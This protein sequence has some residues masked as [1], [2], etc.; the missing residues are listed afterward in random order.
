MLQNI[1]PRFSSLTNWS[2]FWHWISGLEG[3]VW[4][5]WATPVGLIATPAGLIDD[6]DEGKKDLLVGWWL[7]RG[8]SIAGVLEISNLI[9]ELFSLLLLLEPSVS[10]LRLIGSVGSLLF[11]ANICSRKLT[12][13]LEACMNAKF[14]IFFKKKKSYYILL[15][16]KYAGKIFSTSQTWMIN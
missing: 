9:S 3:F 11:S 16:F 5:S 13:Q 6:D 2:I 4:K 10:L 15:N 12:N 14:F 1:L 8:L 7:D